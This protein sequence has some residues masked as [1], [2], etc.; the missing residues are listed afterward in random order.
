MNQYPRYSFTNDPLK[1][2]T[3]FLGDHQTPVWIQQRWEEGEYAGFIQKNGCGHCCVA[4]AARLQGVEIDPYEE[5]SL[6]CSMWGIPDLKQQ[7][8]YLSVAG[9]VKIMAHLGIP[10]L[11]KDTIR[12]GTQAAA[13]DICNAL[14][15]GKQVILVSNAKRYKDNPFSPGTHYILA[16]GYTEDGRILIGN[17]TIRAKDL[18]VQ[19][20][21]FN[22]LE[23][24]LIADGGANPDLT[25]GEPAIQPEN[26][27]YVI[28]G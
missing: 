21:D 26:F 6:C 22:M 5:F 12:Q 14:K 25:W 23:Q 17:S 27:G 9:I 13:Q 19:F 28:V 11:A 15:E 18:A 7:Y 24:A 2:A 20:A 16:V 1:P 4:M 8:G 3:I 10:A